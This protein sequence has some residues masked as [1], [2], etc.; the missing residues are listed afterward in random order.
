MNSQERLNHSLSIVK[1]APLFFS[2]AME[3]E[4]FEWSIS[5]TNQWI[6]FFNCTGFFHEHARTVLQFTAQQK[7]FGL[8]DVTLLGVS[9]E[10][11]KIL[12]GWLKLLQI[13]GSKP[14]PFSLVSDFDHS[15]AN[16]YDFNEREK[17]MNR[18]LLFLIDP[19][20]IIRD[21]FSSSADGYFDFEAIFTQLKT[22]QKDWVL[23]NSIKPCP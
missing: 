13:L 5:E 20:G 15:I 19:L 10:R 14:P 6:G 12:R 9:N 17:V 2:H 11:P 4:R 16:L 23:I 21:E 1:N 22:L 7:Q 8:I 18:K 3:K